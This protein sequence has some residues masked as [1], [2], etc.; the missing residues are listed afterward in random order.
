MTTATN[1]AATVE[2]Q[3]AAAAGAVEQIKD[4]LEGGENNTAP[5]NET[6]VTTELDNMNADFANPR[7]TSR[8]FE[9]YV[10]TGLLDENLVYD[11][12]DLAGKFL[13]HANPDSRKAEIDQLKEE[14]EKL[15]KKSNATQDT[16]AVLLKIQELESQQKSE[17]SNIREKLGADVKFKSVLLAFQDE[18]SELIEF[19]IINF[20]NKHRGSKIKHAGRNTRSA[21]GSADTPAKPKKKSPV[22]VVEFKGQQLRIAEGRGP[23]PDVLNEVIAAYAKE[24]KKDMKGIK[25]PFVEALKAGKIKTVKFIEVVQPVAETPAETT[26]A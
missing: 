17:G 26:A 25:A 3:N 5:V 11:M 8:D 15:L 22:V 20:L 14:A 21:A 24:S 23:L 12:V 4:V 7:S 18:F 13:A 10:K 1:T 2:T 6:P 16:L 19:E 9:K